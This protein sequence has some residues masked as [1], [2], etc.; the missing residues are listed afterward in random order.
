MRWLKVNSKKTNVR[1]PVSVPK[2]N[3]ALRSNNI[4]KDVDGYHRVVLLA[5]GH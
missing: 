4:A 2:K 5:H 3:C 1:E